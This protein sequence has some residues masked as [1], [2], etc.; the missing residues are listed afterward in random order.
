M[1]TISFTN[2]GCSTVAFCVSRAGEEQL[3]NTY[4]VFSS[5]LD[6][7]RRNT[8]RQA[9]F[10]PGDDEDAEVHTK[11]GSVL[12]I[13]S[14]CKWSRFNIVAHFIRALARSLEP[15]SFLFFRIG[16]ENLH[17]TV[18]AGNFTDNPFR[19]WVQ[20]RFVILDDAGSM[21]TTEAERKE[22]ERYLSYFGKEAA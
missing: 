10:E 6:D 22:R 4:S 18:R 1:T 7:L 8:L 15:D 17:D 12:R 13:W 9:L 14:R 5:G 16:S 3:R 2:D 19:I 20:R 21:R 11:D